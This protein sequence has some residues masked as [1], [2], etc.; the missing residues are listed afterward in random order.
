MNL[1]LEMLQVARLAPNLLGDSASLV[2]KF[3]R[4]EMLVLGEGRLDDGVA[5]VRPSQALAADEFIELFLNAGVHDGF[6][7]HTIRRG[8][9]KRADL[10]PREMPFCKQSFQSSSADSSAAA[11]GGANDASG[12][13]WT[14]SSSHLP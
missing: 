13:R 7:T 8:K 2:E 10:L 1:R 4:S 6:L 9:L 14:R 11:G 12:F 5:L 3:I